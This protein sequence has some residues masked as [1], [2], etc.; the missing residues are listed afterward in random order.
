MLD[1]EKVKC[2][3]LTYALKII[4]TKRLRGIDTVRIAGE[5]MILGE[6]DI[7]MGEISDNRT[8]RIECVIPNCE[9]SG[10]ISISAKYYTK[11]LQIIIQ[12]IQFKDTTFHL[13][14]V[15]I[16]FINTYFFESRIQDKPE[17][18]P[19]QFTELSLKF[20]RVHFDG[21]DEHNQPIILT[22][23]FTRNTMVHF[24]KT[25]ITNSIINVKSERLWLKIHDTI[26]YDSV[27]FLNSISLCFAYLQNV[28]ISNQKTVNTKHHSH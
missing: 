14:N 27:I 2:K 12:N 20:S 13:S 3:T 28:T 6:S 16:Q 19:R 10:N 5:S 26:L 22:I 18:W 25:K 15:N 21:S 9:F 8:V 23:M 7:H 17:L 24:E 1:P 4:V 11:Y